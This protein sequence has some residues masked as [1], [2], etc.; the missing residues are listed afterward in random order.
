MIKNGIFYF[1]FLTMKDIQNL[2]NLQNKIFQLKKYHTFSK[3]FFN[4][5]FFSK[6]GFKVNLVNLSIESLIVMH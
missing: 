3:E 6:N 4:S 1:T 5:D 2:N